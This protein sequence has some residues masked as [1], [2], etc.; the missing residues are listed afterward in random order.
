MSNAE[1]VERAEWEVASAMTELR[2]AR[3]ALAAE[4]AAN[5]GTEVPGI[6]TVGLWGFLKAVLFAR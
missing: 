3:E 4:A 6:E 2:E 1:R 5:P